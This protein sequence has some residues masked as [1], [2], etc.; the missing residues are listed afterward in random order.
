[1]SKRAS[2][3]VEVSPDESSRLENDGVASHADNVE[4]IGKSALASKRSPVREPTVDR[5]RL[6]HLEFF[7]LVWTRD[8]GI[9]QGRTVKLGVLFDVIDIDDDL[10]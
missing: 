4:G 1:M 9:T 2:H 7:D 6:V 5:Q 8:L 10:W 3:S